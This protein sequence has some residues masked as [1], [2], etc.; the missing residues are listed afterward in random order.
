MF[1]YWAMSKHPEFIASTARRSISGLPDEAAAYGQHTREV[2]ADAG[3][4]ET[5]IDALVAAQVVR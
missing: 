4:S 3:Y 2:L 1:P 5:E